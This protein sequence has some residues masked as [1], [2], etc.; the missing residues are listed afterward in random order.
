MKAT[1]R[2][3]LMIAALALPC[4]PL[5]LAA[6]SKADNEALKLAA[7][8]ALMMTPPDKSVPILT[9]VLQGNGSDELKRRA[10]FVLTQTE[11]PGIGEILLEYAETSEG[12][13]QLEAVRM[14][15][16]HG[17]EALLDRLMPLY[18]GGTEELRSAVLRAFLIADRPESV[19]QI[20]R[21]AESD[22]EFQAAV[23]ILGAMEATAMLAQFQD[24]DKASAGLVR[25]FAIAGDSESLLKMA[26]DG[27]DKERQL[28][29][30]QGLGIAGAENVGARL[31]EIYQGSSDPQIRG[32]V[33][34][35]LMIADEEE[36]LLTL[37]RSSSDPEEKAVLLK[38]LAKMDSDAAIQAINRTLAEEQ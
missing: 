37:F 20:A 31:I 38:Q 10:L 27:R 15:G 29:A 4:P 24:H 35:G 5:A 9:G 36:A 21:E 25:A 26:Q 13:L 8:E 23:H 3:G 7:I 34:Q 2:H 12:S 17:D 1:L 32:A 22:E 28:Q 18:R 30:I 19:L 11:A 16:I 14:I 6:D 33:L